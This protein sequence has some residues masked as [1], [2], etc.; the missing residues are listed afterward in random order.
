MSDVLKL[1]ADGTP[2]SIVPLST[3]EWTEAMRL[4]FVGKAKVI[5]EYDD[6]VI[7]SQHL[8]MHVPSIII[9]NKQV[10][11]EKTLKYSK[12]NVYLRDDF[13]CQLQ[14]TSRC[15]EKLGKH[16]VD[17]LTLDH[18]VPKSHGGKTTWTNVTTC[19]KG[20]NG[21]KGNDRTIVPKHPAKKPSYYEILKK[22]KSLPLHIKVE[23]WRPY[24][25]WPDHLVKLVPHQRGATP[26]V[27]E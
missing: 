14:I 15:R 9:M 6:W 19:C 12:T 10:K 25:N 21:A 3:V 20:C 22:R 16:R 4:I 26:D 5:K 17:E 2:L 24:V 18:I 1:N 8:T 23:D 7:R 13:T 11:W 27:E